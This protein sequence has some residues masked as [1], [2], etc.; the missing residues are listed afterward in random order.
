MVGDRECD[1]AEL[2]SL[3]LEVQDLATVLPQQ[4]A[5][6]NAKR[7]VVSPLNCHDPASPALLHKKERNRSRGRQKGWVL[8]KFVSS[9]S[10]PPHGKTIPPHQTFLQG[11]DGLAGFPAADGE[12]LFL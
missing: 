6:K 4:L 3:D 1:G 9:P 12:Q 2:E 10:A 7:E 8:K 11:G 5:G